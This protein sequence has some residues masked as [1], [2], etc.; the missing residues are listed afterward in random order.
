MIKGKNQIYLDKYH[1]QLIRNRL[2]TYKNCCDRKRLTYILEAGA[3]IAKKYN[4]KEGY[5]N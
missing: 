1:Q 5:P 4:F 2:L 3:E